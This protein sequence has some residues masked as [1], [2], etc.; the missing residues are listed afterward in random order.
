MRWVVASL[1]VAFFA[2]VATQAQMLL[3]N[4]E[5]FVTLVDGSRVDLSVVSDSV[6]VIMVRHMG[7]ACSHCME[8][9]RALQNATDRIRAA[10]ARAYAFSH[11][12]D[13]TCLATQ[14]QLQLDTTCITICS[15]TD[16]RTAAALGCVFSEVDGTETNLHMVMVV[17]RRRV[18]FEHFSLTPLMGFE[19]VIAAVNSTK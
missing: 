11:D 6:P 17:H 12:D 4:R 15:D 14:E 3:T 1:C 16:N 8:Q 18:L 5:L 13:S 7:A 2:L 19:R 9:I 10:G